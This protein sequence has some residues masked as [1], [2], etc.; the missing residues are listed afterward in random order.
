MFV[1]FGLLVA[2]IPLHWLRLKLGENVKVKL[3]N[4]FRVKS[5]WN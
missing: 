1:K 5:D 4:L 3:R 2:Q